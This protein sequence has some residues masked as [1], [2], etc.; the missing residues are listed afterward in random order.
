VIIDTVPVTELL[1]PNH[2]QISAENFPEA[3]KV[4]NKSFQNPPD[5]WFLFENVWQTINHGIPPYRGLLTQYAG[6]TVGA[7]I[8]FGTPDKGNLVMN[9]PIVG[10]IPKFRNQG[11]GSLLIATL[12]QVLWDEG[13][14]SITLD[15]NKYPER[16]GNPDFWIKLGYKQY[17][18]TPK[19]FDGEYQDPA[20]RCTNQDTGLHFIKYNLIVYS[21]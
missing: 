16:G 17:G 7:V 4:W 14:R 3:V 18:I 8:A 10:T 9:I 15:T 19:Y 2:A 20:T 5:E 13:T 21:L 11:V 6:E 1:R 12:E